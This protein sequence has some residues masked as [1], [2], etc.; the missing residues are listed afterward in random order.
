MPWLVDWDI[1][2]EPHSNRRR[3][4]R[5]LKKALDELNGDKIL[6]SSMSVVVT[7]SRKLAEAIYAEAEAHNARNASVYHI[8]GLK[9]IRQVVS[10]ET[11][12]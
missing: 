10:P 4:Y 5:R 8:R 6:Y 1:P 9:P 7:S 11:P 3:F 2:L 12:L